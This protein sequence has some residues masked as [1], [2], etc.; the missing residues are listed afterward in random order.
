MS[1]VR[2][3]SYE[4]S[5]STDE[6][7]GLLQ[8]PVYLRYRSDI[9]GETNVDVQ[10]QQ[11][12]GG[13]RVTVSREKNVDVPAFAKAVLGS[14]RRATE[15][16]FWQQRGDTWVAEY[17]IEVSGVPVVAKGTSTLSPCPKGCKYV[18]TFDATA[19][20]PLIGKRI[21]GLVA[22]GLVEQLMQNVQRN[23]DA[24]KRG[25]GLGANSYIGG[26]TGAVDKSAVE[27]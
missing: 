26:L 18:S 15:T 1:T 3:V 19:R 17:T 12:N 13:V 2:T 23:V 7:A 25:T 8:D 11:L 10:V 21:E 16:T 5:A 27:G 9:A 24:L 4:Y 22:D 20:I 14:A 6:V